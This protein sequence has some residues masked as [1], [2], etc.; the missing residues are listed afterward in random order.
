MYIEVRTYMTKYQN[1]TH[2][3]NGE[4]TKHI[5][6]LLK[7]RGRVGRDGGWGMDWHGIAWHGWGDETT[8]SANIPC[9]TTKRERAKT[10]TGGGGSNGYTHQVDL[11]R[12]EG[13]GVR[14]GQ[15]Q[16]L[17]G[18]GD[19][20]ALAE[21]VEVVGFDRRED[22]AVHVERRLNVGE[23]TAHGKSMGN[24][25]TYIDDGGEGTTK[26]ACSLCNSS[27][28]GLLPG[29]SPGKKSRRGKD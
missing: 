3:A 15:R 26:T 4:K 8:C 29:S 28:P 17:L 1:S 27:K 9:T 16:Q 11:A 14:E 24:T 5:P 18:L 7:G 23:R 20:G 10:T 13:L 2:Q 12:V 6:L 25:S 19:V 21:V 22:L